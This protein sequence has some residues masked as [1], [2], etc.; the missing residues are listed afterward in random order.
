MFLHHLSTAILM[1]SSYM[2]NTIG[3]GVSAM[4]LLDHVDFWIGLIR[5]VMDVCGPVTIA[6]VAFGFG[7]TFV[8]TRMFVFP[9]Y[10]IKYAGYE[11]WVL[12]DGQGFFNLKMVPFLMVLQVLNIHWC[13][14]IFKMFARFAFKGEAIDM[15]SKDKMKKKTAQTT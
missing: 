12:F 1:V 15:H 2:T 8:Y 10:M 4:F 13:F 5:V 7:S 9:I 11:T 6:F 14:L 3:Q